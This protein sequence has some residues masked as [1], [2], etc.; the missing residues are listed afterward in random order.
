MPIAT[1]PNWGL[2]LNTDAMPSELPPGYCTRAVNARFRNGYAERMGGFSTSFDAGPAV[3]SVAP[4]WIGLFAS[5]L[6]SK[7]N[8]HIY[9]GITKVYARDFAGGNSEI[10]R[11]TTG[12]TISSITFAATTATVTTTTNHGRT[13]GDIVTVYAALPTDYNATGAITVTGATTFTYTMATTP[14][15]NATYVGA[16]SYNV[17]SNFTGAIDDRWSGFNLNGVFFMNHPVDGLYYWNGDVTTRLRKLPGS[18]VYN[19]ARPFLNYAVAL[20]DRTVVWSSA[21]EPG[22]IPLYWT[23]AATN[24]AGVSAALAETQGKLV[25]SLTM[26][27]AHI[28]Y[29]ADARY[30]MEYVGGAKVFSFRRIAP[31]T[32]GLMARGCVVDTPKGHVFLNQNMDVM[33]HSGGEAVSI[34]EGRVRTTLNTVTP[35][36]R[37]RAF[38][39]VN[40]RFNEVWVCFPTGSS[41]VCDTALVWN[42]KDDTWGHKAL[43]SVTYATSG[44]LRS[45]VTEQYMLACTT[46]ANRL[47][48]ADYAAS[49]DDFGDLYETI[50]ERTGLT[51][52]AETSI[53]NLSRS[54][55]P[56]D[57]VTGNGGGTVY[58]GSSMFP[59]TAPTY[60]S[61]ITLLPGST[62]WVNGLAT[63]GAY[64]AVK[65]VWGVSPFRFKTVL[66]DYTTSGEA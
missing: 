24:D 1:I 59:N 41:Q 44:L 42:W 6:S 7:G 22:A 64:L 8:F 47:G 20:T 38:L 40:Q 49:T 62:K 65:L 28:V 18:G 66:V 48:A 63:G 37:K 2:G 14:A 11:Y 60:I 58:H 55:W 54:F 50:V 21:A 5:S 4:Y 15:T 61:P 34:A 3:A 43:P 16:Y 12:A 39:A 32:D 46:Y 26:G 17:V 25:D 31:G 13:T 51:M 29:A 52:G 36:Y 53:K 19:N 45:D 9:A 56:I 33:I 30:A 10:T 57:A 27:S 23:A 35:A